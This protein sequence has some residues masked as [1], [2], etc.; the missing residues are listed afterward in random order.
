MKI[1][2]CFAVGLILS[3]LGGSTV[4][5]QGQGGLDAV[6]RGIEWDSSKAQVLSRF[7][8][9]K[10]A[11]F[12]AEGKKVRD[13]IMKEKLRHAKASE[14]EAI[15]KSYLRLSGDRTGYEVSVISGEFRADNG[16]ALLIANEEKAQKYYLFVDDKLWK[17]VVAYDSDYIQGIGFEAFIDAV[18]RK[19]GE[20][21]QTE[22]DEGSDGSSLARAMWRDE[23]TELRIEDKSDFFNTFTM[24]FAHRKT[25]ERQAQIKKA[26]GGDEEKSKE[27]AVRTSILEIQ[28]DDG[29]GSDDDIVD[30]IVGGRVEVNVERGRPED[31]K[32]N[33]VG[34]DPVAT[35]ADANLSGE[36]EKKKKKGKVRAGGKSK[37]FDIKTKKKKELIVY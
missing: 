29:F 32:V 28:E 3:I 37:G 15:E 12:K 31:T 14:V 4:V 27:R 36:P 30:A 18:S 25:S 34:S 11:E 6:L 33:R 23:N 1:A 16:E 10:D 20:P 19:Y 13:P 8:Q 21:D 9:D 17:L 7:K 26:F 5:A 24:V 2:G 22:F 35:A